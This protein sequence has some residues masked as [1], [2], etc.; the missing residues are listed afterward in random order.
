MSHLNLIFPHQLF[1]PH[2]LLKSGHP[3]YL[4]EEYL[5]FRQ[6]GF[7]KQKIAFHRASMKA[8]AQELAQQG[9]ELTYI[10]AHEQRADLRFLIPELSAQGF[11]D[12]YVLDPTDNWLEKRLR[13]GTQALGISLHEGENPLFFHSREELSD[14]FRPDKKKFFQTKFYINQRKARDI[15]VDEHQQPAG[16]KWTY[17]VDNRKKYPRKKLPPAIQYPDRNGFWEEAVSYVETNFPDYPGQLSAQPLYPVTPAGTQAWLKDFF[18]HRFQEFGPY[19]DA[20][21]ARESIL[22]HSVMTPMLNVGLISPQEIVQQSLSYAQ[23]HEIPLNSLEGFIRQIV[24]WRE[25]IRGVY[26]VKGTEERTRNFWG[27]TRKIPASFYTGETGIAPVDITIRKVLQTGY[28]HHIE[29]LMVLGNFMLLCEFDPD[30]VYRW[31]MELFIDAYDWVMVPNVY[32]MSQFA[33]GG[34]MSTKPYI[35]G[36]NYLLKMSDYGKGDWQATW[37]GLFWRF[38]H[39]HRDFFLKNPRLGML[40]RTFDKM[41]EG[42]RNQHLLNADAYLATVENQLAESEAAALND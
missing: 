12:L 21:V 27:F 13:Q 28:C 3:V 8:F 14:F 40:V 19:E 23:R 16:G 34:L 26:Q 9:V 38:M 7:H 25:F 37:D 32:G 31:F 24:G 41:D 1:R 4:I 35:S 18:Q 5:F 10:E 22:H 15:L 36:S 20:I 42:K 29:R 2:P 17:D 39:V 30:E 11:T 33:D 6:Y